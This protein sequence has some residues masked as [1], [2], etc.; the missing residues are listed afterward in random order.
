MR[1]NQAEVQRYQ[2]LFQVGAVP[3]IKIVELEDKAEESQQLH[4][5]SL[6]E[7]KQSQLRLKEEQNRY[8]A[9]INQAASEIKQ[10]KLRLIEQKNSGVAG[11][12]YELCDRPE[13]ARS[14]R[15]TLAG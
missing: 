14:V 4:Q 10:A 11:T 9:V 13:R 3:Q 7:V 6:S 2:K 8:Q 1:R 15:C 12:Q 5:N